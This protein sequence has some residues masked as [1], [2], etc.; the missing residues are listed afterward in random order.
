MRSVTGWLCREDFASTSMTH[1]T[2]SPAAPPLL[3]RGGVG[4]ISPLLF[5]EGWHAKR[6]G[7]ITPRKQAS[8]ILRSRRWYLLADHRRLLEGA[9]SA[10]EVLLQLLD[11]CRRQL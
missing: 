7:V 11:D 3:L 10:R 9:E 2:P 5:K 8:S 1:T 4:L 6:D